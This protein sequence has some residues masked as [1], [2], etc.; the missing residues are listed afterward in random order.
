MHDRSSD[1]VDDEAGWS[2]GPRNELQPVRSRLN[3]MLSAS[4]EDWREMRS[5]TACGVENPTRASGQLI[6]HLVVAI[7]I[8]AQKQSTQSAQL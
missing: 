5:A 6:F 7:P 1:A 2:H 8:A 4:P 3:V